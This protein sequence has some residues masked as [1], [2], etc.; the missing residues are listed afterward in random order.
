MEQI[1]TLQ[2]QNS[3]LQQEHQELQ[4]TVERLQEEKQQETKQKEKEEEQSREPADKKYTLPRNATEY[5]RIIG[6]YLQ[7][8]GNLE[9]E[10]ENLKSIYFQSIAVTT[11]M[12]LSTTGVMCNVSIGSLYEQAKKE[13]VKYK[14]Y[15]K[16][17]HEKMLRSGKGK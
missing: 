17:I 6:Q 7:D 16:W 14:D 11:K 1:E 15:A 12:N 4:I 9:L 8:N 2:H 5:K 3:R 10:L 13:K